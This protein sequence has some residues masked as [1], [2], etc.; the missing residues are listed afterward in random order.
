MTWAFNHAQTIVLTNLNWNNV[1]NCG[2]HMISENLFR[3]YKILQHRSYQHI[4]LIQKIHVHLWFVMIVLLWKTR[5]KEKVR[6]TNQ[7]ECYWQ[8]HPGKCNVVAS[9]VE[10]QTRQ[11][12]D[13][14]A[15]P[16]TISQS[17]TTRHTDKHGTHHWYHDWGNGTAS[18]SYHQW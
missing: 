17:S 12:N 1:L 5:M 4:K 8:T 18:S 16:N 14:H 15:T 6:R 7:E 13:N 9:C 2:Q 3:L 11:Q 10:C